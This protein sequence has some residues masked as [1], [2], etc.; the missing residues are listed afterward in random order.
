MKDARLR[1]GL[2]LRPR[3]GGGLLR[4]EL[5]PGR[6][7]ARRSS[8]VRATR[9]SS[10]SWPAGWSTG[11]RCAKS[12]ER[13][14]E[15]RAAVGHGRTRPR[16]GST[17]GSAG[18]SPPDPGRAAETVPHRADPG[19][20]Q[21]RR[22]GDAARAGPGGA[23]AAAASAAGRRPPP[24]P[25]TRAVARELRGHDPVPGRPADRARQAARAGGAGRPGIT[26]HLDG[27]LDAL[28]LDSPHRPRLVHRLDR[29]TSGVLVLARTPGVAAKL[30]AAF[31]GRDVQ[32]DLLGGGR[33]P[34]DAA[35]GPDRPA[36]A[37]LRR[38]ARRAQRA[39]RARRRGRRSAP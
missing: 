7:G 2:R 30:A 6:D 8:T 35:G 25:P 38:R 37:A 29:D 15:R 4:P 12:A 19:R 24:S 5:L 14:N 26:R 34:P 17:A 28:R 27:M 32:Q 22:G 39:R 31:R 16:S 13:K 9:A 3:R 20:R 11:Q 36:A 33:R 21:A 23:R 1:R 18:T 10:A